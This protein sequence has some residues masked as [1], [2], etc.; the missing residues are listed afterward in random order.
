MK[1]KKWQISSHLDPLKFLCSQYFKSVDNAFNLYFNKRTAECCHVNCSLIHYNKED[2]EDIIKTR[3]NN[4]YLLVSK[5]CN[6]YNI[7]VHVGSLKYIY[8]SIVINT[9][10]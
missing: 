1:T 7:H 8:I 4:L 3:Q 5:L 2:K 9:Y 10:S 6:F